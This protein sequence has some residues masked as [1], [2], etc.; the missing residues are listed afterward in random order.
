[1]EFALPLT[2]IALVVPA[3]GD[4]PSLGAAIV[5]AAVAVAGYEWPYSTGLFAA[6][7][8]GIAAGLLMERTS[9]AFSAARDAAA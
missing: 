8:A 7:I 5:A 3:L 6:A 4:R 1:L 2:F 9:G